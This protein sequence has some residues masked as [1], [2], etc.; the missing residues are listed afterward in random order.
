M[1]LNDVVLRATVALIIM[2]FA[3]DWAFKN[4]CIDQL[5]AVR[6]MLNANDKAK[7]SGGILVIADIQT[8]HKR[9]FL[10]QT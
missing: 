8:E 6:R 3:V 7:G 1:V 10:E 5:Q 2:T 4:Q 9:N